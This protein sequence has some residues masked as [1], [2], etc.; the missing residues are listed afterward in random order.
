M[1]DFELVRH[2]LRYDNLHKAIPENV[3]GFVDTPEYQNLVDTECDDLPGVVLGCLRRTILRLL[4]ERPGAQLLDQAFHFVECLATADDAR[5]RNAVVEE[6]FEILDPAEVLTQ[7]F[8]AR[9]GEGSKQ[10]F[11]TI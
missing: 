2:H 10:L 8:R 1:T 6:V 5:V 9:L 11:A 3:V 7:Q 4:K